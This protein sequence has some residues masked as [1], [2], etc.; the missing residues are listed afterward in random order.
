MPVCLLIP[1]F[2]DIFLCQSKVSPREASV[3]T[4]GIDPGLS[5]T[6]SI[7]SVIQQKMRIEAIVRGAAS[8]FITVAALSIL[9][10]ILSMSGAGIRFIFGLGVSQVVDV[11]AHQV[12]G[13][14]IVL[15][16]IINGAVAGVLVLFWN[17]AR[18]G[19]KWAF[20]LGMALYA[21]D[22]VILVLFQDYLAVAVH[23]YALYRMYRGL[24][25]ISALEELNQSAAA[26]AG[27]VIEAR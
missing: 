13:A 21:V 1:W 26:Q 15:D 23:A 16:L 14:G 25:M 6:N 3:S 20:V 17:F 12:G 11:M 8:W 24:S 7:A 9:N 27:G 4:T 18:Q 19:Q 5:S 2:G 22:A 10:T